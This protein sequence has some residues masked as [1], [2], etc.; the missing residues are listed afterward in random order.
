MNHRNFESGKIVWI[1]SIL[2]CLS[3]SALAEQDATSSLSDQELMIVFQGKGSNLAYDGGVLREALARIPS[4][5]NHRSIV[6]G[7]SSGSILATYFAC[8]GF[9]DASIANCDYQLLN[10]D[11]SV[12]RKMQN[13]TLLAAKSFA[14]K[15]TEIDHIEMKAFVAFALG[16]DNYQHLKTLEDVAR[17]SRATPRFPMIIVAGNR[18]V[19]YDRGKGDLLAARNYKVFDPRDWS[20]H[21]H[22]E[23]HAFYKKHPDR[24]ASEHPDLILGDTTYIGKALTYFVNRP[25]YDLLQRIPVEERTGDLRLVETPR[26]LMVAIMASVA[27]PSYFDPYPEPESNKLSFSTPHGL[28]TSTRRRSYC[29]GAFS[30]MPAQDV[31]RALPDIRILGTGYATVPFAG[32]EM[33]K[34]WYLTDIENLARLTGWWC[35]MEL[36]QSQEIRD[37]MVKSKNASPQVEFDLGMRMAK[38]AFD[39]GDDLPKYVAVPHYADSI[40][41]AISHQDHD[42]WEIGP[43]N[44]RRLKTMRGLGTLLLQSPEPT[45]QPQVAN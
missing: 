5:R 16:V 37:N 22:P 39:R 31:R 32:R 11:R 38:E 17:A 8:F 3:T 45:S 26:D 36:Q 6:A 19:L 7:N 4:L 43:D 42:V 27:E 34:A 30:N 41:S 35:D 9:T 1:A 25:M 20:V 14:G 2:L 29:G 44:Q 33:I 10:G 40:Q 12:V 15:K 13:S 21:W 18:E 23:V 28:S 24:F